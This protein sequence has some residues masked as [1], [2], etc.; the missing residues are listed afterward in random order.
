MSQVSDTSESSDVCECET[1]VPRPKIWLRAIIFVLLVAFILI[2]HPPWPSLI[3]F[4]ATMAVF[5]GTF[6]RPTIS[7]DYFE[8][9]WFVCFVPV[10]SKRMS[11]AKVVGIEVDLESRMGMLAG[12]WLLGAVDLLWIWL[13]DWLIPWAGGDYRLWL[14]TAQDQRVLVWQGN[15]ERNFRR[16]AAILE[17]VTGMKLTR[18]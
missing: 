1:F 3:G 16:N 5:L 7:A 14:R 9:E 17:S 11:L 15:G 8:K 4:C 10:G 6:P 12:T 18:G 13:L 2:G